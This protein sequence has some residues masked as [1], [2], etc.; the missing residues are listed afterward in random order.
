VGQHIL[1]TLETTS[2]ILVQV[3]FSPQNKL[4]L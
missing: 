4:N 1:S 2:K 3:G